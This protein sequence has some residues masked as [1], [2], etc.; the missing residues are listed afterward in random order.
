MCSCIIKN[1][2]TIFISVLSFIHAPYQIDKYIN[3]CVYEIYCIKV[4]SH[5]FST[6]N[7]KPNC[8]YIAILIPRVKYNYLHHIHCIYIVSITSIW[9]WKPTIIVPFSK[10]Y[11]VIKTCYCTFILSSVILFDQFFMSFFQL[12]FLN[13]LTVI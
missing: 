8:I 5:M 13:S 10:I 11:A 9:I 7:F 6:S 3:V 1:I 12:L 2:T 4:I